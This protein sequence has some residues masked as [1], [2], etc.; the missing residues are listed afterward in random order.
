MVIQ[1]KKKHLVKFFNADSKNVRTAPKITYNHIFPKRFKNMRVYLAEQVFSASILASILLYIQPNILL[2][3]S[4]PTINFI[5]ITDKL[6]DIFNS[7]TR[8]GLK[9][10]KIPIAYL[11]FMKNSFK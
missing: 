4:L 7:S 6:F 8:V 3:I 11:K 5:K 9:H 10:L 2:D 1:S